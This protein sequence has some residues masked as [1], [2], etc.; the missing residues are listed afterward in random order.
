MRSESSAPPWRSYIGRRHLRAPHRCHSPLR[1]DDR[2]DAAGLVQWRTRRRARNAEFKIV[3]TEAG[4]GSLLAVGGPNR[5]RM[6]AR[7]PLGSRYTQA[8]SR[9]GSFMATTKQTEADRR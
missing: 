3:R 6:S 8:A 5:A 2:S 4:L 1:C 9:G 7:V